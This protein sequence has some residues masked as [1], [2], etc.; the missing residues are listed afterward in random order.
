MFNNFHRVKCVFLIQFSKKKYQ[1]RC[2][3]IILNKLKRHLKK[4][5]TTFNWGLLL[6]GYT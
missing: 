6:C 1:P 3:N 4:S 2:I 5:S